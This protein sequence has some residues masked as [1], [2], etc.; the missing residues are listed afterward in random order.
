MKKAM[1]LFICLTLLVI[2]GCSSSNNNSTS[3]GQPVHP[4]DWVALHGAE[5]TADLR[6]CQGCHG[7]DFKGGGQAVSCFNCHTS[8]PPFVGAHPA[9]WN[10]DPLASH[11]LNFQTAL[12][13]KTSWTTCAVAACHGTKLQGGTAGPTCQNVACHISGTAGWPPRPHALYT[14]GSVHG[15][16]AKG[17]T[18]PALSMGN[19]CLLCHGRPTN[20][21]DGGFVTDGAIIGNLLGDCSSCHDSARAHPT[22]W[23]STRAGNVVNHNDGSLTNGTISSSCA[24]CHTTTGAT[25]ASPFTGA[26]TCFSSSHK[27]LNCHATGPGSAPH[28]SLAT[29]G[30]DYL[31]PSLHGA[32]AKINLTYCQT[33][34][35]EPGGE[36]SNPRFNVPKGTMTNG[37]EDCHA[38]GAAHP[39][40][41]D[42]WTFNYDGVDSTRRT[43]FA[44][45]AAGTTSCKLC[46]DV[47]NTGN[48]GTAPACNSCHLSTVT[49]T[50]DCSFCHEVPPDSGTPNLTGATLVDHIPAGG[51]VAAIPSHEECAIC[52]GVS[53][54]AV[55]TLT[56]K[57]ADYVLFDTTNAP[58]GGDHLDGLIEV[59]SAVGYQDATASLP[60]ERFGCA[61]ACHP[62]DTSHQLSGSGLATEAGNYT[63]GTVSC[64]DCHGYPPD[65]ITAAPGASPASHMGSDNGVTLLAQHGECQTCHGTRDS[66][67]GTHES[68]AGY[69]PATDHYNGQINLNSATGYNSSN[70]GCDSAICH[71]NDASHRIPPTSGLT[72]QLGDYGTGSCTTCHGYPPNG[73]DPLLTEPGATPVQHWV[74][75]TNGAILLANHGECQI[76]HGTKDTGGAHDPVSPYNPATMHRDG[77]IQMNSDT[78]YNASNNGCDAAGCHAND[79]IHQLTSSGLTVALIALG[80]SGACDSCHGGLPSDGAPI[81]TNAHSAHISSTTSVSLTCNLCHGHNGSG[82]SHRD[83]KVDVPLISGLANG[84]IYE[85][86]T[87]QCSNVYC[88]G[89]MNTADWDAGTGGA[90]GDCHGAAGT[91]RP[92]AVNEPAGGGHLSTTHAA[93]TCITCH[94]HNGTDT[95]NHVNGAANANGDAQISTAGEITTHSYGASPGSSPDP[96]GFKYS[97]SNCTTSCHGAAVWGGSG[98]CD[99]CHGYPPTSINNSHALGMTPVNHDLLRDG[100]TS[101]GTGLFD[102]HD[103]CSYCHGV[104]D[105]GSGT[106]VVL[107]PTVLGGTYTYVE[108]TDH[109]TGSVT[110][111]SGAGYTAVTGTCGTAVCHGNDAA[112][113]LG[114]GNTVQGRDFGPGSCAAC[115]SSGAGG[116]PVVTASST[117]V[118]TIS[119]GSFGDCTDCHSG[120][121]GSAGG[122]DI[123]LPPASWTNATGESHVTGNMQIA[124]GL[125]YTSHNG[126]HLGGSGTVASISALST[127]A[128]ICWA[129]HDANGIGEL[130]S[131]GGATYKFGVLSTAKTGGTHVSDW[132]NTSAWRQDAYDSRLTR[133]IASVHAV[134]MNGT[135]GHSSSVA[136][137]VDASGR[138]NRGLLNSTLPG[139]AQNAGNTSSVILE[140]RQDIRC[141]YCHDV[142]SLNKATGD[143]GTSAPY[144]R[145]TWLS[146]P[147]PDDR[148]PTVNQTYSGSNYYYDS[149]MTGGMPRP[150]A[151][152]TAAGGYFIDQNSGN[153]TSGQTLAS[154]AG[155]CA[156]CHGSTVDGMDY[157]LNSSLWV[158]INGHNNSVLGGSGA[159]A[160]NLFNPRRGSTFYMAMQGAVNLGA[161]VNSNTPA[162]G[163]NSVGSQAYA[164]R[165]SGWYGGTV[166]ST[167]RG[168]QYNDWYTDGSIGSL[169]GSNT[170]PAHAFSCSKCHSPHATGLP[171][172]LKTNC[173]DTEIGG[174]TNPN[175]SA[176]SFAAVQANNCHRKTT[177]N[178]AD[179]QT[180]GWNTLAPK[181]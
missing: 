84:G 52:H 106:M 163:R 1:F 103:E 125:D 60:A 32:A 80:A 88:H 69:A 168:A 160:Q 23:T 97:S 179:L 85:L 70:G 171:A 124:L 152:S 157:Y 137:N 113:S 153:P 146:D 111:N 6:S 172:L 151:A 73:T 120:H 66:G 61:A 166:G 169:P 149:G 44:G 159:N 17:V 26:P 93:Q 112:H 107:A 62:N 54:G 100:T 139:N 83:G 78:S 49:F 10:A 135:A 158:G 77:Q 132:T 74:S 118:L 87:K 15:P 24:L 9:S 19:Y 40:G 35:A 37:C 131:G 12:S 138:I 81:A 72:V 154:S 164:T 3:P 82:T 133:P 34:H 92:D 31:Q 175:K 91:G 165:N 79:S 18:D 140:N 16:A 128:E 156:L 50:L 25:P 59:N 99:F 147:Y 29:T 102:N 122:V 89:T 20:T 94:P 56:P 170:N 45:A 174:W 7:F 47:E 43:H 90:C 108:G 64:T 176:V 53:E 142:H 71:A 126:I 110:M 145:G 4:A 30:I 5:A 114:S 181:Q 148:P 28:D 65:A 68:L 155:L 119:G 105:T 180:D 41:T 173:L 162:W 104:K 76:C 127:E 21:F 48:G 27:G 57:S 115:H 51:S 38:V 58:Q 14:S 167:T 75:D 109:R 136:N 8:G 150:K 141:S 63:A 101:I 2:A 121:V 67:A 178:A 33:C 116:A 98:G 117:H 95:T 134:N 55:G 22:N 129:C 86:T 130:A 144:L 123:E 39:S 96:D 11:Q 13:D 177:S 46:H 143:S 36:G 161:E 42:R